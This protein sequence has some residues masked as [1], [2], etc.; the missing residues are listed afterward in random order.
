MNSSFL[1]SQLQLGSRTETI[2]GIAMV[3]P[4]IFVSFKIYLIQ[5]QLIFSL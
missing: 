3:F 1:F 2:P 4:G 5:T